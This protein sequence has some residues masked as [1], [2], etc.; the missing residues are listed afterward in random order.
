MELNHEDCLQVLFS[1]PHAPIN[2]EMPMGLHMLPS[3]IQDRKWLRAAGECQF[4]RA[5]AKLQ[6]PPVQKANHSFLESLLKF[7]KMLLD[8]S[9]ETS[10]LY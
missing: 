10:D 3:C 7:I 8:F 5:K 6:P 1:C 9:Q 4:H 2:L